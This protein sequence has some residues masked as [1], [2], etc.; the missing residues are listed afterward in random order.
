MRDFRI[1]SVIIII[2][3]ISSNIFA[4]FG[5]GLGN[6][7]SP[8]EISTP[9]QFLAIGSDEIYL[10]KSFVLVNDIDMAGYS[11]N[12]IAGDTE[13][14]SPGFQGIAFT[15]SFNG[16]GNTISNLQIYAGSADYVGLFGYIGYGGVI[17]DLEIS[18]ALVQTSGDYAGILTGYSSGSIVDC[19]VSGSVSAYQNV[20][21]LVGYSQAGS[22]EGC[23]SDVLLSGKYYLGGMVGY[24]D[25]GSIVDSGVAASSIVTGQD[26]ST[27]VG[28]LAGYNDGTISDCY[29]R[30]KV[31]GSISSVYVGGLLGYTEHCEI[32]RSFATGEISAGIGSSYIGGLAG[33]CN[34]V[35]LQECYSRG[36]VLASSTSNYTG[37]LI[38]YGK[39]CNIDSGYSWGDTQGGNFVGG[40]I[41]FNDFGTLYYCYCSATV[42]G[43]N[44]IGGLLGCNKY[45]TVKY[46]LWDLQ[47]AG[48]FAV[49]IGSNI[50][51][52]I[53]DVYGKTSQ[54]M[55]EY[56]TFAKVKFPF[57]GL[58][59][60]GNA[61]TWVRDFDSLLPVFTWQSDIKLFSGG[62][63]SEQDPFIIKTAKD[64]Y[65]TGD[66][67]WEY[68][69]ACYLVAADI[70]M[71]EYDG[72]DGRLAY[73]VIG[74]NSY[75]SSQ[76]VG[77]SYV[78]GFY[79]KFS[80]CFDGGGYKISNLYID[81]TG[82]DYVGMFGVCTDSSV[83]FDVELASSQV[84]GKSNVAG[85]IGYN[86][87]SVSN[88][89]VD[90]EVTGYSTVGGLVGYNTASIIQCCSEGSVEAINGIAGG[91][92]G[93]NTGSVSE[94]FSESN[95]KSTGNGY[96]WGGLI[97]SCSGTITNCY[98][99]GDVT[100][101]YY[102]GG[103][104]GSKSGSATKCFSTGLVNGY[105]NLSAFIGSLS[106][107]CESCY[108]DIESSGISDGVGNTNPDP[109]TVQGYPTA[110]MKSQ[111]T[112]SGFDFIGDSDGIDDIWAIVANESYPKLTWF[113]DISGD[114]AGDYGVDME[115]IIALTN[116][117]LVCV[118]E[119]GW[120]SNYD[121]DN[122]N[123]I[124]LADV[125]V[126]AANWL[127]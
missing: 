53:V 59:H 29:A 75:F 83:I 106:G 61:N 102:C 101:Y 74:D 124:D 127:E 2:F 33:Y 76:Y 82:N 6:V 103:L 70:D 121:L 72:L 11:F 116:L 15:G 93:N 80:G 96:Y 57:D 99:A 87:G 42:S 95:I 38:G 110:D 86:V 34:T 3:C 79:F 97:G 122:N 48:S 77:D 56:L 23:Q 13:S 71:S 4:Q 5:G 40:F 35:N 111:G 65:R 118:G 20:G 94:C 126:I 36:D 8:Y 14:G 19:R 54:Q 67:K 52:T 117:W 21:G 50:A 112:F 114:I 22:F 51:G 125:G 73:R 69:D 88:C 63:G 26:L 28:G 115:D 60:N 7:S 90:T 10:E 17:Q 64:L 109:V 98:A 113:K 49:G 100:G 91:L 12:V 39:S 27:Y 37:G 25:R 81:G 55:Q 108:W 1:L 45:G 43:L 41:G 58:T 31:I 123:R 104:F 120:N 47:K 89:I 84:V 78:S 66:Y 46:C 107:T 119:H 9:E 32:S 85:L 68:L 18:N 16:N 105:S 24:N 92:I 30:A 44:S 62:T